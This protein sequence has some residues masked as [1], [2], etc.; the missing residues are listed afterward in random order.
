MLCPNCGSD[1]I[2]VQTLQENL[3]TTTVSKTKSKYKEKG[4]GFFW[5]ITIGWWWWI[6]D[7]FIWFVAFVPRLILQLFINAHKRKSY[8]G[9]SS[10]VEQSV[11][12]IK[13]VTICT[14]QNCGNSWK[15]NKSN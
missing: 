3:G 9:K 2:Q 12:H 10:T 6:V 1:K 5:W 4:H 7:L 8:K 11:N 13:Y 14:C 15:V